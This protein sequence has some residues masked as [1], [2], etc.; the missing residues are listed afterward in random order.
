M[1][2]AAGKNAY[3]MDLSEE[4]KIGEG[5]FARVHRIKRKKDDLLC[6]A[7]IIKTPLNKMTLDEQKGFER[8]L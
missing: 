4:T 1:V 6:A 8:E 3:N 7:K 2:E 5:S